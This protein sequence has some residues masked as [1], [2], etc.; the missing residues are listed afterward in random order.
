MLNFQIEKKIGPKIFF[1]QKYFLVFFFPIFFGSKNFSGQNNFVGQKN[2]RSTNFF[3]S[4]FLGGLNEIFW[5][6]TGRFNPGGGW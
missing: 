6:E 4:I 3:G 5:V 2:S 1:G